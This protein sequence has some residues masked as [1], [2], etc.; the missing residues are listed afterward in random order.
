MNQCIIY[1]EVYVTMKPYY[2]HSYCTFMMEGHE[3]KCYLMVHRIAIKCIKNLQAILYDKFVWP[4]NIKNFRVRKKLLMR[5][6][7]VQQNNFMHLMY[8]WQ[9]CFCKAFFSVG[10]MSLHKKCSFPLTHLFPMHPFSTPW[11]HQKT[12]RLSDVFRG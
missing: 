12:V 7:K 8:L 6:K 10:G 1:S 9:L 5:E 2:E 11:K 3:F 4:C